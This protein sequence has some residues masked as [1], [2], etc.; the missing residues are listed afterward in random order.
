MVEYRRF[1]NTDPPQIRRLW[2]ECGLGRGAAVP[3][4]ADSFETV[5]FSQPYFDPNGLI[6]AVDSGVVVGYIHA[7]FCARA[8][9]SGLDR[10]KGVI[11]AAMVQPSHR[12]Q[13][14]GRELVRRAEA[15]LR[16]RGAQAIF[17]GPAHPR[18]PF[19]FGI[20][21][22]SQPAGF[23]E[24]DPLAQPFFTSL[25]YAPVERHI[26]YQ[27]SLE[28]KS[29]PIGIRL[30]ALRRTTQLVAPDHPSVNS[31][32]WQ[33]RT[34]RLDSVELMLSP[35]SSDA[36]LA[37]LTVVGLDFYLPRWNRRSIGLMDLR[38]DESQRRKG[39]AQALLVEVCRRVRSEMIQLVE[40]HVEEGDTVS[41][42]LL[43]SAGF[44]RVDAGVVYR[45]V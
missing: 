43:E 18:D 37:R 4:D 8:N 33:T 22:G 19:Y 36:C 23:L 15:Y 38:V 5:V 6:V 45:K 30:M 44:H 9:E 11:C 1:R 40:A 24:S 34:G 32:W 17:A 25:G 41:A 3:C 31:W 35:K 14:I 39:Y 21:G 12:R 13:G 29:D 10:S 27:R 26:V 16:E 42:K 20:Y 28:D 2:Q 7:G